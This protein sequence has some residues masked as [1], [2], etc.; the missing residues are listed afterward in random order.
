MIIHYSNVYLVWRYSSLY[1]CSE[2]TSLCYA[3]LCLN[4]LLLYSLYSVVFRHSASWSLLCDCFSP[5]KLLCSIE[6]NM[7]PMITK[8]NV[9]SFF[10]G[11][12]IWPLSRLFCKVGRLWG[13]GLTEFIR[14]L[15]PGHCRH[16]KHTENAPEACGRLQAQNDQSSRVSLGWNTKWP[17]GPA[18]PVTSFP[19][20]ESRQ[21]ATDGTGLQRKPLMLDTLEKM[22]IH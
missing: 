5:G 20:L 22:I 7:Q 13:T 16:R 9:V 10:D 17:I 11:S 1:P 3:S 18:L 8:Y 6:V 2:H 21:Q 19:P 12:K 4:L 14:L 15:L